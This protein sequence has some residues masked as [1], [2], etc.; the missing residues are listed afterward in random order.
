MRT[1]R[2]VASFS[3]SISVALAAVTASPSYIS[4]LKTFLQ[5][6]DFTLNG[7]FYMYDFNHDGAIAPNDWLYIDTASGQAFRLMGK[8]PTQN[9]VFGWLPL[10]SL[11]SDLPSAPTG[12]FIF[13]NFPQDQQLFHTNAFSW[14]YVDKNS[15]GVYKLMG[16]D[17]NHNFDYLD[18][19]G[20]GTADPLSGIEVSILGT[21]VSFSWENPTSSQDLI[22][23]PQDQSGASQSSAQNSTWPKTTCS[24]EQSQQYHGQG[25][26]YKANSWYRGLITYDC[27]IDAQNRWGLKVAS[28]EISD[29]KRT[30]RLKATY[31]GKRANGLLEFNYKAGTIHIKGSFDGRSVDCVEYYK[32][33]APKTLYQ[34]RPDEI[35]EYMEWYGDGPCDPDFIRST[36]PSWFY[37]DVNDCHSQNNISDSVMQATHLDLEQNVE[38]SVEDSQNRT[39]TIHIFRKYKIDR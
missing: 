6:H 35:Q 13:I 21:R 18:E 34:D 9:D 1:L 39:H 23:N 19:N 15:M 17:Q 26:Y 36:C 14:V 22:N 11:P 12:Y 5:Q 10:S 24:D 8:T 33:L 16:A 32:P 2:L 7:K 37:E 20:D 31:D 27:K 29:L 25:L 28:L 3:L 30:E 38:Y 4:N